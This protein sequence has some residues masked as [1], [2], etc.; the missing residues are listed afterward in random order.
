MKGKDVLYLAHAETMRKHF[1]NSSFPAL[2]YS[3]SFNRFEG[4]CSDNL[5]KKQ[6]KN[7]HNS[8]NCWNIPANKQEFM[9]I[10]SKNLERETLIFTLHVT[11]M[12]YIECIAI[13]LL[14]Y[15]FSFVCKRF[16]E[17]FYEHF[18]KKTV[19]KCNGIVHLFWAFK[20][21]NDQINEPWE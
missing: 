12:N 9:K 2:L 15:N 7:K 5:G 8:N 1:L 19:L 13:A 3:L 21:D 11:F 14:P 17:T 16:W 10:N 4:P 6:N 20:N 18:W